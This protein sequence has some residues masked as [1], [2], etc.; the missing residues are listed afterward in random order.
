MEVIMALDFR[1]VSIH[2]DPTSGITQIETATAVFQ[3][4][5]VINAEVVLKSFDIQYN[6]GD[7]HVLRAQIVPSVARIREGNAVDVQ[8]QFLLR[9]SSGNIDD[10]FSGTIE[11]LVIAVTESLVG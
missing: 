1:P 9:D 8:V 2:F 10:P 4:R 11:V 3:D 5:K 6:N 7:H